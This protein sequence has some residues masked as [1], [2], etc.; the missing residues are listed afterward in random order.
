MGRMERITHHLKRYDEK[1][2]C[3]KNEEG[4]PCVYRKGTRVETYDVDGNTIHF[5][6]PTTSFVFA[7][8]DTWRATGTPV[9]WGI[10]PIMDH[11]R[12]IDCWHRDIASDL[13]AQ[14]I[15]HSES[16]DRARQNRD[17]DFLR[18]M[19]GTFK[20]TF[21]DVVTGNMDKNKTLKGKR[22]GNC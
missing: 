16:S 13:I 21:D 12:S 11:L 17:E 3:A 1:L 8:T 9:E 7:I 20:K 10:L 19:R 4:K 14:E 2:F 22:Y 5:V 15:K 18:E 6:R